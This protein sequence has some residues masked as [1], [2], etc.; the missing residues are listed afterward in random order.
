MN[1]VRP[2]VTYPRELVVHIRTIETYSF[3]G[4]RHVGLFGNTPDG[5]SV[6][7]C[8]EQFHPYFFISKPN[9]S[10]DILH[11]TI[12]GT[13]GEDLVISI[14]EES[15]LPAVGYANDEPTL[16]YRITYRNI[17]ARFPILK[18]F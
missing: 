16:V 14:T 9:V 12:N 18:F 10:P 4:P 8:I 11:S 5:H 17:H 7:I 6:S 15:R 1:N 13:C 2:A 3:S